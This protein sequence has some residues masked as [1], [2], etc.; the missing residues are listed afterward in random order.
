MDVVDCICTC[1][2]VEGP[3][4]KQARIFVC[5]S[6]VSLPFFLRLLNRVLLLTSKGAYHRVILSPLSLCRLPR[7]SSYV[8]LGGF[9]AGPGAPGELHIEPDALGEFYLLGSSCRVPRFLS[10]N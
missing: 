1:V 8:C 3:T 2:E 9:H 10:P 5:K 4:S 7:V 6:E